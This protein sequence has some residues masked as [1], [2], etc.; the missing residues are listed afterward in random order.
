MEYITFKQFIYT[1]NIRDCYTS[2]FTNKEVEDGALIRIYYGTEYKN[3]NYIDI[4]WYDYFSKDSVWKA[5]EDYLKKEILESV[6][7][8]FSFNQDYGCME[9]YTCSRKDLVENLEKIK[10]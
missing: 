6:V 2:A 9:I 4:S 10:N 8:D 5:L 3:D 7:T 1:I